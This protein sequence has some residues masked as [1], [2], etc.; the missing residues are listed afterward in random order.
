MKFKLKEN[1]KAK[2]I[3]IYYH[4]FIHDAIKKKGGFISHYI[5]D[6]IKEFLDF[7]EPFDFKD[8]E[9]KISSIS[10]PPKAINK[11]IYDYVKKRNLFR[12]RNQLITFA[13]YFKFFLEEK[14]YLKDKSLETYLKENNLKILREA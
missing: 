3:G 11:K 9:K 6:A 5:N 7:I 12:S 8:S 14:K 2:Q 10:T 4:S 1:Q 13:I